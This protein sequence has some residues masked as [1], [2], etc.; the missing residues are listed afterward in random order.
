[1]DQ[2]PPSEEEICWL[3]PTDS[4]AF[5][6][7]PVGSTSCDDTPPCQR[8]NNGDDKQSLAGEFIWSD[9]SDDRGRRSQENEHRDDSSLAGAADYCVSGER[10]VTTARGKARVHETGGSDR[11]QAARSSSEDSLCPSDQLEHV[12]VVQDE[13]NIERGKSLGSDEADEEERGGNVAG[14]HHRAP[15]SAAL[16]GFEH[17]EQEQGELL[18]KEERVDRGEFEEFADFSPAWNQDKPA[19]DNHHLHQHSEEKSLDQFADDLG[20]VP[21]RRRNQ[22]HNNVDFCDRAHEISSDEPHAMQPR[23]SVRRRTRASLIRERRWLDRVPRSQR[24]SQVRGHPLGGMTLL[25]L[26]ERHLLDVGIGE[27]TRL[28]ARRHDKRQR[29]ADADL[30]RRSARLFQRAKSDREARLSFADSARENDWRYNS[31][32]RAC[33]D[34]GVTRGIDARRGNREGQ[35]PASASRGRTPNCS[36]FSLKSEDSAYWTREAKGSRVECTEKRPRSNGE[37]PPMGFY[38]GGGERC[39]L[40]H[41]RPMSAKPTLTCGSGWEPG[42]TRPRPR[43]RCDQRRFEGR[44]NGR[45][46]IFDEGLDSDMSD[47]SPHGIIE[48]ADEE[49]GPLK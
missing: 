12:F 25:E 14:G 22:L 19:A 37:N 7:S 46:E 40:R 32:S 27:M 2:L 20:A 1:M 43:H 17:P 11:S 36:S 48:Y 49:E 45:N 21:R 29:R 26:E 28:L 5:S 34:P 31:R 38:S 6:V 16:R 18:H 33:R 15:Q 30:L 8:S 10:N 3:Q 35:R 41:K 42:R 23:S 9:A 4:L 13:D 44:R 39:S 24:L 47:L